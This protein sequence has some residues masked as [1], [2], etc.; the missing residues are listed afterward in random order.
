MKARVKAERSERGPL[1]TSSRDKMTA[2]ARMEELGKTLY[3]YMPAARDNRTGK[4]PYVY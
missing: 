1:A 2:W 4:E 3:L